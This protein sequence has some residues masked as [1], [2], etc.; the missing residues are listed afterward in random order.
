V[1]FGTPPGIPFPT[2]RGRWSPDGDGANLAPAGSDNW[3]L[4]GFAKYSLIGGFNQSVD[5][6]WVF[7]GSHSGCQQAFRNPQSGE[8]GSLNLRPN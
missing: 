6:R 5:H 4:P 8:P 2:Y 7:L 1:D 3:P